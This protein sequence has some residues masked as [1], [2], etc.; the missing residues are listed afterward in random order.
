[1]RLKLFRATTIAEAMA[2]VRAELGAE[3]LILSTRRAGNVVEVTAALEPEDDFPLPLP[4]TPAPAMLARLAWH[5]V[6]EPLARALSTGDLSTALA[7]QLTFG[8]L[9]IDQQPILLA[10]PPGAGKTLTVARLAARLVMAGRNPMV[11]TADGNRAGATEQ[12]AAFT[13][14]L[15]INLVAASHPVALARAFALR[16]PGAPVLIDGPGIDP[17]SAPAHQEMGELAATCHAVT[18]LV[19]AAGGDPSESEDI[20]ANFATSGTRYL[21]ATKL[22]L[23]RRLGGLITAA[24]SRKLTLAEAGIGPGAADGLV[25]LPPPYSP[26]ASPGA[27]RHERLAETGQADRHRLRKRWCWQNLVCHHLG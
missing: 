21:V 15:G 12:L 20:A 2:K 11:I 8:A 3:A 22:D 25:P 6:P 5:G 27:C 23:A 17:F 18:V 14:L 1:M 16:T 9:P 10:G 13:R 26:S 24:A 4:P 19:L 7:A